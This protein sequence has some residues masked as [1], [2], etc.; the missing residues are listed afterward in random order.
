MTDWE[1]VIASKKIENGDLFTRMDNDKDM[2]ICTQY[3]MKSADGKPTP[4]VSNVTLPE[5][6]AFLEKCSARLSMAECQT[7]VEGSTMDDAK[8]TKIE[9][10]LDDVDFEADM[11]LSRK[12][13]KGARAQLAEL[14]CLRGPI[15]KQNL[16]RIEDGNLICDKRVLDTRYLLYEPSET[17]VA[18]AAP[19][20]IRS[21]WDIQ[22]EYDYEIQGETAEVRD[23]WDDKE[24][25][26]FIDDKLITTRPNPYGFCPFIVQ[27]PACGLSIQEKGYYKYR[28]ESIFALLRND[29]GESIFDECNFIATNLKTMTSD[30]VKP[31]LMLR[32]E[33]GNI[34][35]L[36]EYPGDPGSITSLGK[37]KL[38][39]VPKR[40]ITNAARYY[41]EIIELNKQLS[42]YTILDF[43]STNMPLSGA[44]ITKLAETKGELL[45]YRLGAIASLMEQD[46]RMTIRQLPIC[47]EN[48]KLKSV[49]VGEEGHKREYKASDLDGEY[50]IK[51]R[52]WSNTKED[53]SADAAIAGAL[54]GFYSKDTIRRDYMKSK[55]PDLEAQKMDAEQLEDENEIIR[56]QR[57]LKALIIQAPKDPQ[58][59]LEAWI[60][61]DKIVNLI[62][63]TKLDLNVPLA[64]EPNKKSANP[65][66]NSLAAMLAN[67]QGGMKPSQ[68]A[69]SGE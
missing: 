21:K 67:K 9:E 33:D 54:Q 13:Q 2:A 16:L 59:N 10:F 50:T 11:L 8:T 49:K 34:V 41:K 29:K 22:N 27:V 53:M 31:A 56:M 66:T 23:C 30:L 57:Q 69:I 44:A 36:D 35:Y 40:D 65:Q 18:W 61:L 25:A 17:G 43:G 4:G 68:E 6:K 20:M 51:Y 55:N 37:G 5:P 26:I 14:V 46:A 64:N 62:K 28:G 12:G 39:L 63:R 7:V 58:K 45:M 60:L 52:F 48:S 42:T 15:A 1:K 24:N 3:T 47:L 32:D 38:E 19:M